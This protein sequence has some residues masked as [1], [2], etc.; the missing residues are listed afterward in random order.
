[1]DRDWS[2]VARLTAAELPS[3]TPESER[4]AREFTRV[5]RRQSRLIDPNPHGHKASLRALRIVLA[6]LGAA[7]PVSERD[8]QALATLDPNISGQRVIWFLAERGLLE[9]DPSRQID[10]DAQTVRKIIDRFPVP[11]RDELRS[12]VQV[13]K[14]EGRREHPPLSSRRILVYVRIV[15][16]VL[17]E[18]TTRT[19]TLRSITTEEFKDVLDARK[20]GAA[21]AAHHALRSLFRGLKQE[22]VIFRDPT[23]GVTLPGVV[24]LPASVPSDRLAVL[25][26]QARTPLHRLLLGL[27]TIHAV[28]PTQAANVRLDDVDLT[29]GQLIIKHRYHRRTVYLDPLTAEL[30][31]DW[32]RERQQSWPTS[33]NPHLLVTSQ[34]ALD[35]AQPPVSDGLLQHVFEKIGIP[36]RTLWQDRVLHEAQLTGDP[37]H[38]MRLF[39]IAAETAMKYVRAAHPERTGRPVTR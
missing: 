31:T 10:R 36:A 12:W 15:R 21:R 8:L 39:G 32:L 3:L 18:W 27:V 19:D 16:P 25:M 17:E 38:L 4:I 22:R 20:P 11:M 34:T 23:R 35:I 30:L 9:P 26:G 29:R 14:G 13:L 5:S 7:A 37:V 28:T 24:T 1:M 2:Q 6:W 33:T